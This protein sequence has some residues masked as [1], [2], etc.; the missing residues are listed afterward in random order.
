MQ[1]RTPKPGHYFGSDGA[2][3]PWPRPDEIEAHMRLAHEMRARAAREMLGALFS[4]KSRPAA[5]PAAE[6]PL[7]ALSEGLRAPLTSIRSSAEILR[8]HP[9]I[10]PQERSR[11]VSNMLEAEARLEAVVSRL[12]RAAR[13]EDGASIRIDLNA[14]KS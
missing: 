6:E 2:E 3:I 1:E 10:S 13:S 5:E 14:L 8:D 7:S 9:E 4:I 11:F 12:M